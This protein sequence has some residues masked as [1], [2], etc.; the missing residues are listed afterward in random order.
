MN[1]EFAGQPNEILM[2]ED[3]NEFLREI[4]DRLDVLIENLGGELDKPEEELTDEIIRPMSY[5]AP[6]Q[7]DD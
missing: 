3:E 1:K 6:D 7:K 5:I 2:M 4:S